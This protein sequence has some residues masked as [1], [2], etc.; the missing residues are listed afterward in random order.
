MLPLLSYFSL[1]RVETVRTNTAD[2][3][4]YPSSGV[5]IEDHPAQ[6][7]TANYYFSLRGLSN[8]VLNEVACK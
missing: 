4:H 3:C 8:Q 2:T 5:I 7:R 1:N 6:I